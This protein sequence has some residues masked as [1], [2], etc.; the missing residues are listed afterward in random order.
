MFNF[1]KD[2]PPIW[3]DILLCKTSSLYKLLFPKRKK[4]EY[5]A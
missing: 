4:Y 1:V 2:F 3:L 5:N